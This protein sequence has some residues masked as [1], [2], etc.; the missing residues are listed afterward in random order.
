MNSFV[1]LVRIHKFCFIQCVCS[2]PL[3]ISQFFQLHRLIVDVGHIKCVKNDACIS[4]SKFAI[5]TI[6]LS[7]CAHN[8]SA[9]SFHTPAINRNATRYPANGLLFSPF[10]Q[11]EKV[12]F[13]N[14]MNLTGFSVLHRLFSVLHQHFSTSW[15]PPGQTIRSKNGATKFNK[16]CQGF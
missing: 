13:F 5:S 6:G 11:M 4:L 9:S 7:K 2:F 8:H 1:L 10:S 3:S 16:L 14:H 15:I 12:I